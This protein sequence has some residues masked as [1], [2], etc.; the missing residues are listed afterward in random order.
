MNSNQRTAYASARRPASRPPRRGAVLIILIAVFAVVMALAAVWG[1][2]MVGDYRR[3]RRVEQRAQAEW[4][5]EAGVR[6]AAARLTIDPEY[7]GETWNIS[8]QELN[9]QAG[10]AVEISVEPLAASAAAPETTADADTPTNPTY[11]LTAR[12]RY[13]APEPRVQSTKIIEFTPTPSEPAS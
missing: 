3:Q 7:D 13:P 9:Q 1:K 12:A 4:L 8:A 10:A 11:R 6:R 5:A 2:R